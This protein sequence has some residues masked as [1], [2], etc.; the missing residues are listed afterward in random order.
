MWCRDCEDRKMLN[1][2][3]WVH[4]QK[5]RYYEAFVLEDL[6]G[7]WEVVTSWGALDSKRGGGKVK[8]VDSREA[9]EAAIE[10]VGRRRQKR[11]YSRA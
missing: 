3:R 7:D 1:V 2:M 6:L 10:K 11:G 5:R 9:A 4:P 8:I